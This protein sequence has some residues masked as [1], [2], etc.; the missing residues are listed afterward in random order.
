MALGRDL[1]LL[2]ILVVVSA[3]T[4]WASRHN[5][6]QES[7]PHVDDHRPDYLVEGLRVVT[8][9]SEGTPERRLVSEEMRH[10]SNDTTEL[11]QPRLVV[12]A[13]DGA[14]WNVRAE[15]G[16][17]GPDGAWVLFQGAVQVH[18]DAAAGVEPVELRSEA[19]RVQ[20]KTEYLET[21]QPVR[22]KTGESWVEGVGLEAW[23][24]GPLR[25]KLLSKVR[26]YY[27]QK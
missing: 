17:V 19:L 9:S 5:E 20:P 26:G 22:I 1:T 11:D 3:A 15:R 24:G 14:Q 25:I 21:D 13:K 6:S 7:V 2:A 18:R 16:R 27:V 10:Y 8:M 23:V 12:T 4:W